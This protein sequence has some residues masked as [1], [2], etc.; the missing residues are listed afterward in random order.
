MDNYIRIYEDMASETDCQRWIEMFEKDSEHHQIQDN[1][2]GA[3]LTQINLLH[4]PD[5]IWREEVNI[6]ANIVMQGV[7][8]YKKDCNIKPWQFPKEMGLEPPKIKKYSPS[9]SSDWF[10]PHVDVLDKK[11]ASRF[12]VAFLYLDDNEAGE[13]HVTDVVSKCKR[14][15]LLCFPPFFT[16][17]HVGQKP[18]HKPKYIV[19]SYLHYT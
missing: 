19:G 18:V 4:S 7:E 13:T 6:L 15:S 17:P 2:S 9:R 1:G 14:G 8:K 11:T 10:P 16:H 12:L 3:T 5:T